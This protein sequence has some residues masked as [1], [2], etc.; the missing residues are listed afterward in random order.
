[1]IFCLFYL[2]VYIIQFQLE[3]DLLVNRDYYILVTQDSAWNIVG[4]Q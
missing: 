3:S 2:F 4:T 1:M